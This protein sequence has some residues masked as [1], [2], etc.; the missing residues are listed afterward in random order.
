MLR[1]LNLISLD[2]IKK[3]WTNGWIIP[4][5][6]EPI[7]GKC[8]VSERHWKHYLMES[9]FGLRRI[10]PKSNLTVRWQ[11]RVTV[12]LGAELVHVRRRSPSRIDLI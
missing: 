9:R 1:L 2:L 7:R 3:I 11:E 6:N 12:R 5:M 4:A 8:A 10:Q